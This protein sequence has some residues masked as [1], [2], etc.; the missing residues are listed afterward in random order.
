MDKGPVA[1]FDRE[2]LPM[3]TYAVMSAETEKALQL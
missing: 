3:L 2:L 1:S